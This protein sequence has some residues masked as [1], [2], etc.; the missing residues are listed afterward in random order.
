MALDDP[1]DAVR[2]RTFLKGVLYYDRRSVAIDYI[3]RDLSDIETR[4][5]FPTQVTIP[6]N[7]EVDI[8]QKQ[9]TLFFCTATGS[10]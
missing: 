2:T 3:V 10:M 4:I 8:S 1:G 6:D 7:V 5:T 9:K